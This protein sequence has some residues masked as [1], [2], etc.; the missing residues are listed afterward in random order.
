M[1]TRSLEEIFDHIEE[2]SSLL[3]TAEL[4]ANGEWEEQFTADMRANFT[5][6][7]AHTQ[8]SGNQ[9]ATLEHIAHSQ[10]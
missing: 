2:F 4:L 3:A 5:R 6:Y 1:A 10:E 7:G 8:L 9:Q